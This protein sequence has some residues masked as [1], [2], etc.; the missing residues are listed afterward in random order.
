MIKYSLDSSE[1]FRSAKKEED[2]RFNYRQFS[3]ANRTLDLPSPGLL[4][5]AQIPICFYGGSGRGC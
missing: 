2:E 3:L 4:K 1:K 5:L